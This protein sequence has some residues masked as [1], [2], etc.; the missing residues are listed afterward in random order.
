M[1]KVKPKQGNKTLATSLPNLPILDNTYT[2]SLAIILSK[3]MVAAKKN[4]LAIF[5]NVCQQ[6]FHL[7]QSL[8]NSNILTL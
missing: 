4:W 2:T 5:C 3:K 8:F 7:C 1:D 6:N